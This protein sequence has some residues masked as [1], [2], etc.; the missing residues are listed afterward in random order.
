V[1]WQL[2]SHKI[3]RWTVPFFLLTLF[4]SS[5]VLA[6]S[7]RSPIYAIALGA[8]VGLYLLALVAMLHRKLEHRLIFR[9]PLFFAN[10]NLS[11]LV[12]WGRFLAGNRQVTWEPSRR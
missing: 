7:Q 6:W 11:I 5:L 8:Q 12:A 10:V 2:W 1:A 3:L 9:I 4:A